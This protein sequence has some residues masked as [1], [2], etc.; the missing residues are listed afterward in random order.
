MVVFIV[1]SFLA[2]RGG[3]GLSF[4][5]GNGE[6][7]AEGG[8]AGHFAGRD[9]RPVDREGVDAVRQGGGDREGA[10]AARGPAGVGCLEERLAED[11]VIADGF[12]VA[13]LVGRG[14]DADEL[15]A[16]AAEVPGDA[17]DAPRERDGFA[18]PRRGAAEVDPQVRPA[19]AEEVAHR[20]DD[21]P[22]LGGEEDGGDDRDERAGRN[23]GPGKAGHAGADQEERGPRGEHDRRGRV[24]G[25]LAHRGASAGAAGGPAAPREAG[26]FA[27]VPRQRGAGAN[28]AEDDEEEREDQDEARGGRRRPGRQDRARGIARV[29]EDADAVAR[30]GGGDRVAG[31]AEAPP[32]AGRVVLE[33]GAARL[34]RPREIAP[35]VRP[36]G[37]RDDGFR[38]LPSSHASIREELGDRVRDEQPRTGDEE[39]QPDEP[40]EEALVRRAL[41]VGPDGRARGPASARRGHE[42]P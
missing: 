29:D 28:G 7:V 27:D 15:E 33:P 20:G 26:G 30:G 24:A 12:A 6:L 34:V 18:R 35:G 37:A 42:Q 2:W 8:A 5:D 14:H 3:G 31:D 23:L 16:E 1:V 38:L 11:F 21:E 9:E 17:L 19:A 13:V 40:G 32:R 39:Q 36:V 25:R 41:A 4:G 22:E 10:L